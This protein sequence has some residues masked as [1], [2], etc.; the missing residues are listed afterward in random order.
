LKTVG[1][2][3]LKNHGIS[4]ETVNNL[5]ATSADFFARP[6]SE[7]DL[8]AWG[9]EGKSSS[10][11]YTAYGG[12]KL[13]QSLDQDEIDSLRS[14]NPDM[15]EAFDIGYER[16]INGSSNIWP[17]ERDSKMVQMK[18]VMQD[19][20]KQCQ[21]VQFAVMQA[22]SLGMGLG[23]NYFDKFL[24]EGANTLRFLHYPPVEKEVFEKDK[25]AV[26]AGAHSDYGKSF[27]S[28]Y[29]ECLD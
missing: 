5:F 23:E 14:S 27:Y 2:V 8:F 16:V 21:Q 9:L 17:G 12:E 18:E 19:F 3:Y 20:F 15:K 29:F 6:Q 13:S 4:Q 22:I 1:F 24:T 25:C 11:G 7:K 26:R 28:P 10:P